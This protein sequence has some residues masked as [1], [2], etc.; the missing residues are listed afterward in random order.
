MKKLS[1]AKKSVLGNMIIRQTMGGTR[2]EDGK[3][4]HTCLGINVC[5]HN[6]SWDYNDYIKGILSDNDN[7]AEFHI[8]DEKYVNDFL[9]KSF[10][11]IEKE[12][13][14]YTYIIY[15]GRYKTGLVVNF[16]TFKDILDY[17][18]DDRFNNDINE[19]DYIEICKCI[20]TK[21]TE[22]GKYISYIP[23]S[24]VSTLNDGN[25][26]HYKGDFMIKLIDEDDVVHWKYE[27]QDDIDDI[28][29]LDEF[30]NDITYEFA[31]LKDQDF[32]TWSYEHYGRSIAIPINY[33]N[34]MNLNKYIDYTKKWFNV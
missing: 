23:N 7:Y 17:F 3:K 9:H 24:D 16:T 27:N 6:T 11:D 34:I 19:H 30:Y 33:D 29:S 18:H 5:L 1:D 14:D 15:K 20:A 25:T 12:K 32:I 4:V 10:D 21:L 28:D 22:I 26:L 2:K 13:P 8:L 31:E